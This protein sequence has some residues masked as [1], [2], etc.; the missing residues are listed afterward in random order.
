M[1]E[2]IK[3]STKIPFAN[4]LFGLGIRHVGLT[5]AKKLA[6]QLKTIENIRQA[7]FEQLI[8]LDDIGDVVAKSI[9][10]YFSNEKNV[11]IVERLKNAGLQFETI[12]DENFIDKLENQKIVISGTF[13]IPR[14]ELKK[15]IEVNNGKLVSSIS[16]KTDLFL[17]GENVGPSKLEKAEK[18]KIKTIKEADFMEMIK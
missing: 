6:K 16:K 9:I 14:N 3:A 2:S 10:D 17:C 18:L 7:T 13:T 5:G 4:V 11:E 12:E 1:I 15:L 8:E